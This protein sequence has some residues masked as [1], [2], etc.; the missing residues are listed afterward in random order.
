MTSKS[1]G[2]SVGGVPYRRLLEITALLSS[3]LEPKKVWRE[4]MQSACEVVSAEGAS[5]FIIDPVTDQ[6]FFEI[7]LG[8][9]GETLEK[10]QLEKDDGI[11]GLAITSKETIISNH[12]QQDPRHSPM[13]DLSSGYVTRNLICTPL[14]VG[15]KTIG[16]LEAVNKTEDRDF[17]DGDRI[18]L[19]SRASQVAIS[20]ENSRLYEHQRQA[21]EQTVL[22]LVATIEKR[23]PYT[24]GHTQRVF[25]GSLEIARQLQ[26]DE[27]RIEKLRMGALLHDIGKIGIA[28]DI[29][30][31]TEG[32]SDS[33]WK[34]MQTHP[35]M[36]VDI[37]QHIFGLVDIVPI[38][39]YHHENWDGQGYPE[40]IGGE[41]IPAESRIIAVADSYDAM[42]SGRPYRKKFTHDQAVWEIQRGADT[43]FD[44][45]M[46]EGFVRAAESGA[47]PILPL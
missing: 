1:P 28:D 19:E 5:L 8:P 41:T 14:I 36:G 9:A 38:V 21:F 26:F 10:L 2:S 32:L 11:V 4:A 15:G 22:S 18:V 7:A 6:L 43:Q 30:R 12:A 42:T 23:D 39:L 29:L 20:L 31:K 44:P 3:S 45:Q 24:G 40:G 47:F 35:E 17:S 33:E 34:I 46:V 25:A 37:F 16:A 27:V 13:V